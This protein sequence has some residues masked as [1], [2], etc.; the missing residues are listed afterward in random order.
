M[1]VA[2]GEHKTDYTMYTLHV[3]VV[4]YMTIHEADV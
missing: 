2:S 3:H 1:Q 4:G